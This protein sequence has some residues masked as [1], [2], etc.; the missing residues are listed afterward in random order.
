MTQGGG[1]T[2]LVVGGAGYVGSHVAKRLARNGWT[3]VVFDDLSSGHRHAVRWGE[4]VE[5]DIRDRAAVTAALRAH[6]PAAVMHFAARIEVGVGEREPDTFY[7][8]NVRGSL[9]LFD[10]MREAGAGPLIF[11][12]TCATYGEPERLPLDEDHPQRPVSVYGRTK[13]MIEQVLADYDRA[14]GFPHAALRYFNASGADRDGE[15]GEEHDPE[16]HLIPNALRAAAGLGAGLKVFGDDYDTR[17]G[18]C[19]RDYIHVEDLAAAHVASLE[20]LLGGAE[21][22]AVNVGTGEGYTV[23]EVIDT[24]AKVTGRAP[25]YEM[26]PRRFGDAPLL[27]ADPTRARELIGFEARSSDLH[28]IV[29]TAWR[30]HQRV[31]NVNAPAG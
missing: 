19:V 7:D 21:S 31:W 23:R 10:A 28:T 29:E 2:V 6:R 5:G 1:R 16:T 15:I 22:F 30:F 20:R 24:V 9:S 25:P 18:T 26:A 12:S 17:D 3:P 13:L 8:N 4:L 14:F 11:S 27:Y